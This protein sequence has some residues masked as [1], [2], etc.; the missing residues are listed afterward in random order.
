MSRKRQR[1]LFEEPG[2]G[3]DWL[4]RPPLNPRP[5]LKEA[6]RQMLADSR[7]SRPQ[8]AE[9]MNAA[10]IAEGMKNRVTVS[11][12]DA[13]AAESKANLPEVEELPALC[14]AAESVLPVAALNGSLKLQ[15]INAEEAQRLRLARLED[16]SKRLAKQ[17]RRL[18][19]EI[20]EG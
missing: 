6:I 9:R 2:I 17:A 20:E 16:E 8:I 4:S 5:R 18:R 11:R 19:Q 10:F 3:G 12:L 7:Y 1:N 15:V 14:W 13:W